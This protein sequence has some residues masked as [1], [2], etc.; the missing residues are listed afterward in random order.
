MMKNK[1]RERENKVWVYSKRSDLA[2]YG[3]EGKVDQIEMPQSHTC[4]SAGR[5]KL[6]VYSRKKVDGE[7]LPL[8]VG[9]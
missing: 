2:K 1:K 9:T 5:Q 7:N 8:T 3:R 4:A 6:I